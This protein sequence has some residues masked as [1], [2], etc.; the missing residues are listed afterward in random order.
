[1]LSFFS[2]M[3]YVSTFI[4]MTAFV[5]FF[6]GVLFNISSI[7]DAGIFY[8]CK[9]QI[10]V[11]QIASAVFALL[12]WFV[13]SGLS[14]EKFLAGYTRLSATCFIVGII[15][16]IFAFVNVVISIILG[17]SKKGNNELEIMENLRKSS[18]IMGAVFLAISFILKVN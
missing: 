14:T 9:N 2:V 17:L 7:T 18:F 6:I 10:K 4:A 3:I 15:W 8:T 12:Y 11:C 1:M 5:I 16:I 13:V